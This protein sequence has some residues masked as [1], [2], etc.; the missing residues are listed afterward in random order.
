MSPPGFL[1]PVIQYVVIRVE[2]DRE[3]VDPPIFQSKQAF[4]KL[5]HPPEL[6][7]RPY[8][9]DEGAFF[10]RVFV[11]HTYELLDHSRGNVIH[12]EE[13]EILQ[14][15]YGRRLAGARHAGYDNN[16]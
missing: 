16:A 7:R 3:Y 6:F 10:N 13:A 11:Y 15:V 14:H 1:V 5:I 9:H 12:A 2:K 8:I 4:A